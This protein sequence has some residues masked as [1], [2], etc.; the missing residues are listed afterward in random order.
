MD[1]YFLRV[2][3][4]LPGGSLPRDN[5]KGWQAAIETLVTENRQF[6]FCNVQPT[7]VFGS[8]VK[9][10]LAG[11]AACL[12]RWKGGVQRSDLVGVEIVQHDANDLRIGI[13]FVHQPLIWYAKSTVVRRSVTATWRQPA[14]GSTIMNTLPVPL[15]RYS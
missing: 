13:A 3:P 12:G 2:A 5:G 4:A 1:R 8:R 9:F 14:S 7:A 15:R 10:E 6:A 11:D